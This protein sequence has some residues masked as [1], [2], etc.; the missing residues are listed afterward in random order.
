MGTIFNKIM[1]ELIFWMA[2]IIIPLVVE[3]IP[4]LGGFFILLKKRI[5]QKKLPLVE[6]YPEI[7]LIIPV[8][9]SNETLEECLK[10]VYESDYDASLISII[11]ANNMSSDNSFEVFNKCQTAFPDLSMQWLNSK[12]GKSKALNMALFNSNGKYIIHIDSDGRLEKS[13]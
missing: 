13:A 11:L 3:I 6:K 10:S 7:T 12:Q 8:F 2:W 9:N 5:F 4:A 1:S